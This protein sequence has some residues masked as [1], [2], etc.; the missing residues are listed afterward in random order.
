MASSA[1]VL[2]T[3]RVVDSQGEL[4]CLVTGANPR[5]RRRLAR[6]QDMPKNRAQDISGP[7]H[8]GS[9]RGLAKH[10]YNPKANY[11]QRDFGFVAHARRAPISTMGRS[12]V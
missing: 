9:A 5:T 7:R 10:E 12:G 4:A 6:A 3:L 1:I 2:H 8:I 11:T